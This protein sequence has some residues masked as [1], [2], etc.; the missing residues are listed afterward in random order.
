VEL[1]MDELNGKR[2]QFPIRFDP[3]F[4]SNSVQV[5]SYTT[6]KKNNQKWSKVTLSNKFTAIPEQLL[7][8]NTTTFTMVNLRYIHQQLREKKRF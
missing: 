5:Q 6:M 3:N 4:F 2:K 8:A 7:C 1:N